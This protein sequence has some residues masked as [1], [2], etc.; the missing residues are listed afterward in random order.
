MQRSAAFLGFVATLL[1]LAACS[2]TLAPEVA[3]PT[4]ADPQTT[5]RSCPEDFFDTLTTHL[6]TQP[7]GDFT[8]VRL[9]EEP[10]YAFRPDALND[11]VHEGCVFRVERESAAGDIMV[12]V[13]GVTSGADESQVLGILTSAGWVQPF[14]DL[15][16]GAYESEE[17]DPV[18]H[19]ELESIGV[20]PVKGPDFVLAFPDWS[21]YFDASEMVLQSVPHI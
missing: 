15:E 8:E 19:G 4:S 3:A 17:R 13:F 6:E 12:Q 10:A 7:A 16:P 1:G 2:S 5:E 14:P 21:E 20:F 11:T 18:G 9:I